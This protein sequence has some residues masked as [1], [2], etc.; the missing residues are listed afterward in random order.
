[1]EKE[2]RMAHHQDYTAESKVHSRFWV[3]TLSTEALGSNTRHFVLALTPD[4]RLVQDPQ[5]YQCST[6]GFATVP[7][8]VTACPSTLAGLY[9][10]PVLQTSL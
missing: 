4:V 9:T 6:T 1:M 2:Q 5:S 7:M 10:P 3:L 8:R